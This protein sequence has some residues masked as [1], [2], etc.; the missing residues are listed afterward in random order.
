MHEGHDHEEHNHEEDN[1]DEH[2]HEGHDH[3]AHGHE[4]HQGQ[5]H[6][7]HK[8]G[9]HD[10]SKH[11]SDDDGLHDNITKTEEREI[12]AVLIKFRSKM[13]FVTWPRL[14]AQNT[15]MQAAPPAIEINRL[16]SL[17]GIGIQALQYLAY[18]IMLISGISIFIAL[19]NTLKE[20]KYEFALLRISGAGRRQLLLLVL[21]ESMFLC[22]TGFLSGTIIG[23]IGLILIS[24]GTDQDYKIAFNSMTIVWDKELPLLLLTLAVGLLA[25]LVPAL[26]AYR[27]NIS[28]TLANA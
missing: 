28:K 22:V 5:D 19:Y 17:F 8:Q 15:K 12:T 21:L 16:F 7:E 24:G 9:I 27:L 13:G 11:D 6:E 18:G 14:I 2:G 3:E 23:R 1:H 4:G 20:R 10:H 26:K 25:G